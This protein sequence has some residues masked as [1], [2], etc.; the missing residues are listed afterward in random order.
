M[1]KSGEVSR[2]DMK[3]ED[4]DED[5]RSNSGFVE[6]KLE[7]LLSAPQSTNEFS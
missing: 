3:E 4:E 6:N 5:I 7:M 1:R 2:R